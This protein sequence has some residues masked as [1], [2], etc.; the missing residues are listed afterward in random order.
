MAHQN[1]VRIARNTAMLY[2]RMLVMMFVTM[3]AS[4]VVLRTL[5]QS[6]ND[7]YSLVGSFV[8]IFWFLNTAMATATQRF[9]NVEMGRGD[10]AAMQ[11]VFSM[12]VN[13]HIGIAL[14]IL[15]LGETI[16]LW[17]VNNLL[18]IPG[19]RMGAANWVYQFALLTS[20]LNIVRVP[21]NATI[22][23]HE[24][25]SFYAVIS[26][27]EAVL[28]LGAVLLLVVLP[29]DKLILYAVLTCLVVLTVTLIYRAYGKRQFATCRYRF[30]R[31]KAL[32]RRMIGFS[33]WSL[34]GAGAN[35]A[36]QK[37]IEVMFN[38][39]V[40]RGLNLAADLAGQISSAVYAFVL[41]F[42]T[43][44]NPQIMK[45]HAAGDNDYF[46]YLIFRASKYSYFL[47]L[48]IAVPVV[49]CA[50]ALL[51]LW[52]GAEMVPEHT[53]AFTRLLM[54]F[55][56][57]DAIS[58]PLWTAVQATGNIRR[59][60]ILMSSIIFLNLPLAYLVLRAGM[61][62]ESAFAVRL[63]MNIIAFAVRVGYLGRNLGFPVWAY[64]RQVVLVAAVVTALAVPVPMWVA[65]HTEGLRGLILTTLSSCVWTGAVIFAVGMGRSERGF[66]IRAIRK[67]L[68]R[69][70]AGDV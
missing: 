33:G 37:G 12:S 17:W 35:S 1:T 39:V 16:G 59:Y 54:G 11:R 26:I 55:L 56:L 47:L 34:L 60:Q 23:A 52:L 4:R 41:N 13:V 53:V 27:A 46:R 70:E 30:E 15:V 9:L 38:M 24:R 58:G 48:F 29:G 36:S 22:I 51:S 40:G 45:S 3:Y 10:M 32:A 31:D 67:R 8:A 43:A 64:V 49:M 25:M 57:V 2:V 5:G 63:G 66:V 18:D 68:G 21:Y 61:P 20:C 69:K 19:A 65:C 28:R 7:I 42:Q 14:V 50:E 44:F 6:D 62:P